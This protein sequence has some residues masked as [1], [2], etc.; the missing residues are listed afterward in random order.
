MDISGV[1]SMKKDRENLQT[2]LSLRTNFV[3][4]QIIYAKLFQV[5]TKHQTSGFALI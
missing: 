2:K 1:I 5:I 3:D 4:G